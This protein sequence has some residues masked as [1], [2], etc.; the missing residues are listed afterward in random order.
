MIS[1][2]IVPHILLMPLLFRQHGVYP[3]TRPGT[4][5]AGTVRKS[6]RM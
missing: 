4:E 2:C 3:K 1:G 6:K 5:I